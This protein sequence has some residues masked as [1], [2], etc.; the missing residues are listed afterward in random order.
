MAGGL[1]DILAHPPSNIRRP[2]T[3]IEK[4]NVL[5]PG[6]SNHDIETELSG[7]VQQPPWGGTID[8]NGINAPKGHRFEVR[9]HDRTP[10]EVAGFNTWGER[11]VGN[12]FQKE[13]LFTDED[14]LSTY[15]GTGAITSDQRDNGSR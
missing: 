11:A 15:F 9:P 8:S 6:K 1:P 2:A 13:L 5:L 3:L 12:A 14:K 10:W 7:F 4:S